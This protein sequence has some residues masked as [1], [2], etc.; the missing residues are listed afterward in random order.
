MIDYSDIYAFLLVIVRM[1]SFFVTAPVF[2]SRTIPGRFKIGLGFFIALIIYPSMGLD[3]TLTLDGTFIYL[4]IQEAILG[5][6]IGFTAQLI[7]YSI[8]V[9]GSFIDLQI[10]FA[11][12]NVIDPQTGAQS[13]LL[14]NFKYAFAILL[15]LTLNIHHL[16]IDGIVLSY[17]EL[18][19][20]GNWIGQINDENVVMYMVSLF[21][22][23]FVIAFKISAPL[24]ITLLFTDIVL[25]ILGRTVPQLNIFVV[26]LPLK[27]LI[28]FILLFLL[29]GVFINNYKD[30][31]REMINSIKQF[32]DLMGL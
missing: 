4:V 30:L 1:T 29:A 7:F 31:F 22:K 25:G 8:Q 2:S 27:I 5:M 6:A 15:M 24:V 20:G 23:M 12:A 3:L 10:G 13:P 14:G 18:P 11:L 16:L 26:G 17:N 32:I 28:T 19:V 9:A 21:T